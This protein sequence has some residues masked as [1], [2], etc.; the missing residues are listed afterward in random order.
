MIRN[1]IVDCGCERQSIVASYPLP[2]ASL[3]QL[4]HF[5]FLFFS[6]LNLM[7]VFGIQEKENKI[8]KLMDPTVPFGYGVLLGHYHRYTKSG[9]VEIAQPT[10]NKNNEFLSRTLPNK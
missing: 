4:L 9:K 7:L 8:E 10:I 6:L 2:Y 1:S 5:I 3:C